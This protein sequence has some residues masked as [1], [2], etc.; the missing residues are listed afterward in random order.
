M[1]LVR[2][3]WRAVKGAMCLNTAGAILAFGMTN[4]RSIS[5]IFLGYVHLGSYFFKGANVMDG[6]ENIDDIVDVAMM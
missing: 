4:L 6:N 3:L 2:D 5:R 1:L